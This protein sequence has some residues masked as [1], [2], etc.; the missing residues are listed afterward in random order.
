MWVK[1]Q[2]NCRS[3]STRLQLKSSE[4][5][6]RFCRSSPY[7]YRFEKKTLKFNFSEWFSGKIK[8]SSWFFLLLSGYLYPESAKILNFGIFFSVKIEFRR[9]FSDKFFFQLREYFFDAILNYD[10]FIFFFRRNS[11]LAT[12][13]YFL[14][15]LIW[16]SVWATKDFRLSWG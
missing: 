2:L 8:N 10:E 3:R 16:R 15:S 1:A 9:I 14:V 4:T 12:F 6:M 13:T 5:L 7:I 11:F